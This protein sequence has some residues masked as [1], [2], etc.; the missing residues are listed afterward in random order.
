MPTIT[1]KNETEMIQFGNYCAERLPNRCVCFLRGDLGAGKTTWMKGVLKG[2]GSQ[3]I[4]RSPTYPIVQNY[5][6]D[7]KTVVHFDLYRLTGADDFEE[8]GLGDEVD[9]A[10][11]L[12]VEWPK[13]ARSQLPAPDFE[14]IFQIGTNEHLVTLSEDGFET[15][16]LT[17]WQK[18]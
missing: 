18:Q 13:R 7:D 15:L 1:L 3:E 12:F 10:D 6:I 8:S 9:S 14:L 5:R 16:K 4:L 2:L 17:D 11:Y